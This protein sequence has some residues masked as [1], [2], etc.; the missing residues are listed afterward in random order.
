MAAEEP[1][2]FRQRP[3]MTMKV[4]LTAEQ[5]A[6][7]VQWSAMV[8]TMHFVD[9]NVVSVTKHP[10]VTVDE[11]P[12]KAELIATLREFDQPN[13]AFSYLLA[14]IEKV[15]DLRGTASAADLESQILGDLRALRAFFQRAR[16]IEP[17]EFVIGYLRDLRRV[18]PEIGRPRYLAF[19]EVMNTQFNLRDPVASTLRLQR[20]QEVLAEADR[21]SI[22]RHHPTVLLAIACIYGN[23][24]AKRLMK[25][26]ADPSRF[27][28]ENAL[29]DVMAI[30]R[31]AEFKLQIEQDGGYGRAKL[32]TDDDGL[33]GVLDCFTP[34]S[35]RI[36][37]K[38][39]GADTAFEFR[40]D[41]RRLLSGV[42]AAN[43]DG[44]QGG[45]IL[46]ADEYE[47]VVR[48]LS[49]PGSES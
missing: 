29:A 43:S 24:S 33:A 16:I 20:T 32:V 2:V 12:R 13:H 5:H 19:L 18:A 40:I 7:M 21:L 46:D 17:D 41:L 4:E 47:G 26:K 6:A 3:Q 1:K 22:P 8:P 10:D 48:L 36:A 15:S 9:I 38:A 31:L 14:L 11:N 45:S 28:A 27:N 37:Q 34:V 25:F 23:R 44:P 35:V 39:D 42:S 30:M 49:P